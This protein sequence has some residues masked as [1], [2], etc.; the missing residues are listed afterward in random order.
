MKNSI[1][2]CRLACRSSG[3]RASVEGRR[4][5]RSPLERQATVRAFVRQLP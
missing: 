2:P 1:C 3:E 5:S 4:F